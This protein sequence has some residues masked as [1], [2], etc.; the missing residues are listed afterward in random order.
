[1]GFPFLEPAF[2]FGVTAVAP[3]LFRQVYGT[4]WRRLV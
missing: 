3:V 4:G 1:V 2:K